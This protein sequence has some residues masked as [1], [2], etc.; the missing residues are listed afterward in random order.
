MRKRVAPDG[1]SWDEFT[2]RCIRPSPPG[3]NR[4]PEVLE[5]GR[6]LKQAHVCA[7]LCSDLLRLECTR[8]YLGGDAGRC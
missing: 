4:H 5:G 7:I 8:V 2:L 1:K 6:W 3:P